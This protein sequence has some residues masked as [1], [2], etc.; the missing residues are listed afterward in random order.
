MILLIAYRLTFLVV[1]E[2]DFGKL[3]QHRLAVS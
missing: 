2:I 3:H 1:D